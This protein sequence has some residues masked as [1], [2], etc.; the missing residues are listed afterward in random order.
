VGNG[1]MVVQYDWDS[2]EWYV[3]I[4]VRL[5]KV[6]AARKGSWNAYI[7]WQTSWVYDNWPGAAK[8]QSIRFNLTKT[9]PVG[10]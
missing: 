1:D 10:L 7:E 8:D 3:P 2:N 9:L 6:F 5:G 4:G